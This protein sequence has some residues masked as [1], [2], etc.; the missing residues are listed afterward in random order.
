M[1]LS[2]YI[3]V[4][5]ESILFQFLISLLV[6]FIVICTFFGCFPLFLIKFFKNSHRQYLFPEIPLINLSSDKLL[7]KGPEAEQG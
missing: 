7:R 1:S 2:A 4:E 5:I 6:K 3:Q